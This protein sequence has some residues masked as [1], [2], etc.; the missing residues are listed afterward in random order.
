LDVRTDAV[1]VT[2]TG[3]VPTI[4]ASAKASEIARGVRREVGQERHADQVTAEL[5]MAR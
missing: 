3:Q 2:L 1:V 5:Q 4:G